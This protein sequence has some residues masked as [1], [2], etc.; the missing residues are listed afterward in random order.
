MWET[1]LA[2]GWPQLRSRLPFGPR[3][4]ASL[5]KPGKSG[6]HERGEGER[7]IVLE[8]WEGTRASRRVE[9]GLSRSFSACGPL[10]LQEGSPHRG[11]VAFSLLPIRVKPGSPALQA[12]SL[13]AEPQGKPKNTGV[14]SLSLLQW[15]C[16]TQESSWGCLQGFPPPPDKD[17]ESPSSTRLEAL[18]PSRDSR[19][20]TRSPSPPDAT[21]GEWPPLPTTREGP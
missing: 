1:C 9:E 20:R 7:V 18:V 16:Q 12:D 15:I 3:S 2:P 21:A 5:Q 19:A 14:G 17:L 4:Q 8:S 11:D 13:P 6:L 10:L